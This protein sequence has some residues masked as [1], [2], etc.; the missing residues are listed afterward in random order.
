MADVH[1]KEVRSYNMSQVKSKKTTP[2]M[3]LRK[4][5]NSIDFLFTLH[6]KDIKSKPDIVLTKY[7]IHI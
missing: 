1:S 3:L 5:L 7:N 4:F 6:K 2:E